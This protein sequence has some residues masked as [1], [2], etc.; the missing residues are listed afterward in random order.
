M[1]NTSN[2]YIKLHANYLL[3]DILS[4]QHYEVVMLDVDG[5]VAS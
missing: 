3:L 4:Q 2:L 5:P 1:A